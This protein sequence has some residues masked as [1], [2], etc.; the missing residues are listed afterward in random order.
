MTADMYPVCRF[1]H[2]GESFTPSQPVPADHPMVAVRP[3]L[4]TT[5]KPTKPTK[6][7]PTKEV[8]P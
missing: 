7:E 3:D 1:E 6:A 5:S 8:T 2:L 4:F